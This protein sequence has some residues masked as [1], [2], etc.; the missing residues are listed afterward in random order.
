[1]YIDISSNSGDP[2]KLI[3]PFMNTLE[4]VTGDIKGFKNFKKKYL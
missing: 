1:M 2:I 4:D 3:T